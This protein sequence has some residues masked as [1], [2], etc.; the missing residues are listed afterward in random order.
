MNLLLI[1]DCETDQ[2][3]VRSCLEEALPD[4]S[5]RV[6]DDSKMLLDTLNQQ[7]FDCVLLDYNLPTASGLGVLATV[8]QNTSERTPPIVMLTGTGSENV[9]VQAMKLGAIDYIRKNDLTPALLHST[10]QGAIDKAA[11]QAQLEAYQRKLT[12]MALH[13]ELTDLGNRPAFQ[14]RMQQLISNMQ[15][16]QRPFALLMM[17]LNKFKPI[18]DTHGH[19][20]GDAVLQELGMRFKAAV[21]NVD[22]IFRLGGDEFAILIE[23]DGRDEE[24]AFVAKRLS[25]SAARPVRHHDAILSCS[26]SI[27]IACAPSHADDAKTLI[28][29][30]DEAMYRAKAS[31]NAF[32][33]AR[34]SDGQQNDD[35]VQQA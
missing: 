20:A 22:D 1:D 35:G 12:R 16:H 6:L 8:Q 30:A 21:R 25:Q 14:K 3:I 29:R 10:V 15:R 2:E 32:C 5:L 33:F 9:A 19:L 28:M 17:D 34:K 27:G 18:N 26:I 13:D 4:A 11:M 7:D 31:A 23:T 24:A